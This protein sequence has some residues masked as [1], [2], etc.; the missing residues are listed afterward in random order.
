[1]D[2]LLIAMHSEQLARSKQQVLLAGRLLTECARFHV[3]W[4]SYADKV[5]TI[6]IV[7]RA[8]FDP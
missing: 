8:W 1:M 5:A 4:Q 7:G 6:D 3:G 2:E